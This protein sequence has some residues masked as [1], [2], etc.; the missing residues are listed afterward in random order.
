MQNSQT[1]PEPRMIFAPGGGDRIG[2]TEL[3]G[4]IGTTP[5]AIRYYE[6]LDLITPHRTRAGARTYCSDARRTLEIIVT[7]RRAGA[8]I[9]QIRSILAEPTNGENLNQK[10]SA[11]LRVRL[12]DLQ[13]QMDDLTSLL[14]QFSAVNLT[15]PTTT[16]DAPPAH[17]TA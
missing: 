17:A 2:I 9:D 8:P 16:V 14:S 1:G 11:A 15:E 12:R 5:R 10:V 4:R 7:L 3:A 6:E 13:D